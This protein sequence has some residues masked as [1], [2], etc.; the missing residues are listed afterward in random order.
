MP[1]Y[2]YR[3]TDCGSSFSKLQR[4]GA[5]AEGVTCPQCGSERI[6]RLLSTFASGSSSSGA[7]ATG[8]SGSCSGFT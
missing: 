7:G 8:G 6:E 1:I 3:C 2:E 4:V 5:S